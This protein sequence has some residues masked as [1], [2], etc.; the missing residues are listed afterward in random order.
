MQI[1]GAARALGLVAGGR[2]G[3]PGLAPSGAI[4]LAYHDVGDDPTNRTSYYVSPA[5]LRKQLS[6]LASFGLRFVPLSELLDRLDASE[7]VDGLA[8]V[9]FDDGLVGVHHWALPVLCELGVP[10]TVFVVAGALGTAPPWWPGAARTMTE[11]EVLEVASAG[12]AVES[13]T[14]THASLPSL[15]PAALTEE[16][17]ASRARLED[18]IGQSVRT[19]AYPFGHFDERVRRASEQNGYRA[20][21]SFL[22]GRVR[23]GD[24]RFRYPRLNMWAGQGRLRLA[25]HVARPGG[26]WPPTQ[27]REV[28]HRLV[29]P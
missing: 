20:G 14:L 9:V 2:L 28:R 5:Q 10:A 26:S 3:S 27:V 18:L 1:A 15:G 24:D 22:N 12:M 4:V 13:H 7:R 25:Y 23:S 11:G 17:G 29:I 21:F 8:S 16:L 6:T 19:V